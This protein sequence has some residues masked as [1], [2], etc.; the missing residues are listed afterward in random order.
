MSTET[1]TTIPADGR[2]KRQ[3]ME[4]VN[5]SGTII[6]I[7]CTAT[8]LIPLY[9]TISMAFKTTGQAVDGNAFSLPAPFSI[10]GFVQ[11]WTLTKFP[12]GAAISL[13][14][15]AGTV[16]A[17]IV[18][19]AF[20]SYAIV[21]NWDRRLF[22]YSFFYLLAAM[23]IPFPVVALPQIQLTGR[24]GLDN[25]FG[26]II[27]AT[28]FQLS[29]SVLLFTAFLRSIPIELEESARIDG[30]TT[31]QTF[32]R[33][34][35]PLLAPMSATVGIFAFLYAWNDFMMPS[36]IISDPALQTLPVRQNL[37]QNQFSNNYNVAFASYLMA[38]APAIVA[39]LFT[40]RW[41]MEGVTQGAVKG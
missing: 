4:R 10:D 25:P 6:L 35:F 1:L 28:M 33:L 14:V 32:W 17:T 39:Y 13:L 22:R 38:M 21:R 29:F 9:V 20:A 30:A 37:F 2:R 24:V 26:V 23:F 36:L 5:W 16:I 31:W 15:T 11:A 27:L 12:V 7:L 19:A 8:I 18:L 3:K 34:I 40:Q 41:V